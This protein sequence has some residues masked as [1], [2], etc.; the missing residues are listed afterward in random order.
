MIGE[1]KRYS[2]EKKE[3]IKVCA[4]C[5]RYEETI[6]PS[7]SV[8]EEGFELCPFAWILFGISLWPE[9]RPEAFSR[10]FGCRLWKA[11]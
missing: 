8:P 4:L 9:Q 7:I 2:M 3:E 10:N 11:M 1:Q 6:N 5:S